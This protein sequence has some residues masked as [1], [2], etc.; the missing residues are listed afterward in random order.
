MKFFKILS[1]VTS[2]LFVYL[3]SQLLFNSV[4]FINDLGLQAT[5][6]ASILCQRTSM[7]MLGFSVLLF[8]SKNLPHSIAR[9]NICLATGITM[10]GLA[11]MGSYEFIKGTVDSSMLIAISL[12]TTLGTSFLI[13]FFSHIKSNIIQ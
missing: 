7:F 2:M 11:C 13:V 4:S 3:F 9:Q 5:D 12:E 6:T 10:I 1:I 8:S